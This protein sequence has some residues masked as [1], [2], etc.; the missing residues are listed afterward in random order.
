LDDIGVVG[1]LLT[2]PVGLEAAD[3]VVRAGTIFAPLAVDPKFHGRGF[4]SALVQHAI[5][6]YDN[7]RQPLLILRGE[8]DFY[9]RFGFAPSVNFDIRPPFDSAPDDYLAL[10]LTAYDA[11][12]RGTVRYPPTF[13]AVGYPSQWNYD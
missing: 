12:Y 1:H 9:G 13:A 10:R 6:F 5:D 7:Q 11:S 2:S 3:G 4:G 8:L